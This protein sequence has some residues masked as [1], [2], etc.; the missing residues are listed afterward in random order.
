MALPLISGSHRMS[1]ALLFVVSLLIFVGL[2]ARPAWS[3]AAYGD[4][5]SQNTY[6][7]DL[8]M[9]PGATCPQ[10]ITGGGR[11]VDA[12]NSIPVCGTWAVRPDGMGFQYM[13]GGLPCMDLFSVRVQMPDQGVWD[14]HFTVVVYPYGD[15][16]PQP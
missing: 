13:A 9:Y 2:P 5:Y 4:L 14:Y 6:W 16:L 10:N 3:C 12:R 1:P 7:Y 11:I 15:P 8:F